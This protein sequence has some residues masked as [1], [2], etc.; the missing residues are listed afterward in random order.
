MNVN[1]G[2]SGGAGRM[3]RSRERKSKTNRMVHVS[4]DLVDEFVPRV[5]AQRCQNED[6]T[7]PRICVAPDITKALQAI[8]QAGE[9]ISAMLSLELPAII[10]VYYLGSDHVISHSQLASKV[11]DAAATGEMWV[12]KKPQ[13]VYRIDYM[14]TDQYIIMAKDKYGTTAKFFVGGKFERVRFQDNWK[15]FAAAYSTGPNE[16]KWFM[17]HKPNISFRTFMSNL[18]EGLYESLRELKRR[19]KTSE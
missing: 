11:G 8:P 17:E 10:H 19:K 14:I 12:M 16:E 9:V 1:I 4:F 6:D 3:K 5:P 7:T 15:N 13:R 18:D 2:L